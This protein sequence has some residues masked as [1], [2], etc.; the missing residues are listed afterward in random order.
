MH[1][2]R[3]LIRKRNTLTGFGRVGRV[4]RIDIYVR[5]V[6]FAAQ[7]I[8]AKIAG[9]D[10]NPC[11]C[12]AGS[13]IEG[14]GLAPDAQHGFLRQFL[15]DHR[16]S[17]RAHQIGLHSRKIMREQRRE[18]L[19]VGV[20]RHAH[21]QIARFLRGK[22]RARDAGRHRRHALAR[23]WEAMLDVKNGCG[24]NHTPSYGRFGNLDHSMI[25]MQSPSV[26]RS[27]SV[28]ANG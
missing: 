21:D 13:R 26:Y 25:H 27:G 3:L 18:G 5:I 23:P 7:A 14:G 12:G 9:N 11:R 2:R 17:A 15:G 1:P 8:D 6:A 4:A 20:L 10:V 28:K 19:S 22:R 16:P 24:T